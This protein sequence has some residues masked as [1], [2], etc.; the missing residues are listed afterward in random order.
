MPPPPGCPAAGL[1]PR[2]RSGK[3][4]RPAKFRVV[5][6]HL[7]HQNQGESLD[8]ES[9]RAAKTSC[10]AQKLGGGG[11]V[12]DV[13][14]GRLGIDVP[15]TSDSQ[16]PIVK[17]DR[18]QCTVEPSRHPAGLE[19][20]RGERPA[21]QDQQRAEDRQRSEPARHPAHGRSPARASAPRW[22]PAPRSPT[23]RCAPDRGSIPAPPRWS[24]RQYSA[25]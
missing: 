24:R 15:D 20:C 8:C 19:D 22:F 12:D 11:R 7:G 6:Q 18:G 1:A 13:S 14:R 5:E 23:R 17:A 25:A 3:A 4:G 21:D 9:S 16:R 10:V 2:R